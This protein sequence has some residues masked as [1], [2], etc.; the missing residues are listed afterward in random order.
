[1]HSYWLTYSLYGP[2]WTANIT[3]KLNKWTSFRQ[4]IKIFYF[5]PMCLKFFQLSEP[6]VTVIQLGTLMVPNSINLGKD[7]LASLALS[8][9]T[10]SKLKLGKESLLY[11]PSCLWSSL[12]MVSRLNVLAIANIWAQETMKTFKPCLESLVSKT[13]YSMEPLVR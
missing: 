8:E 13:L 1:L 10:S 9:T 4:N 11:S 3:W 6:L 5:S 12:W 2:S 7:Y